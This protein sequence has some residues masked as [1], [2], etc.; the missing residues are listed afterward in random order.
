MGLAT[1]TSSVPTTSGTVTTSKSGVLPLLSQRQTL[2]LRVVG[3]QPTSHC[4]DRQVGLT[5]KGTGPSCQRTGQ[6][7]TRDF[8][9]Q[10]TLAE[11]VGGGS[12]SP[13]TLLVPPADTPIGRAAWVVPH[14]EA[15]GPA[16][17]G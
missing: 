8:G 10:G 3:D 1:L 17:R 14:Q 6:S 4:C 5:G 12:V 13:G 7:T 11:L 9:T 2:I 15:S 16:F